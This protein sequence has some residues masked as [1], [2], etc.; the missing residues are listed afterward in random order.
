[1]NTQTATTRTFIA[2][3]VT[4]AVLDCFGGVW[5][6]FKHLADLPLREAGAIATVTT[7]VMWA[8]QPIFGVFADRGHMK[9]HILWGT[10]LTFPMMFLGTIMLALGSIG[11]SYG[12]IIMA[13]I[14]ALARLGQAMFH[15]AA[16]T[17]SGNLGGK[18]RST[19]LAIFVAA[20]AIG[21]GFSQPLFSIIYERA[22][23]H[24][25]YAL[26]PAIVLFAGCVYW[27]RPNQTKS[28]T[29][30][31]LATVFDLSPMMTPGLPRLFF[32][33]TLMSGMNQGLFFLL[34]EFLEERAY[35][36]WIVNGGGMALMTAGSTFAMIPVGLLADRFGVRRVFVTSLVLSFVSY[37][38]VVQ[39]PGMSVPAFVLI[40][41]A[42]GGLMSATNPLG[43]AIGQQISPRNMSMVS[44][45]LMGLAW[46]VGSVS[47]LIV[48]Y[49]ATIPGGSYS[50]ALLWLSVANIAAIALAVSLP[51]EEPIT[52]PAGA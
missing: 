45:M 18:R 25:E 5:P 32:V 43:L 24:T 39:L 38:V 22:N 42:A 31:S 16:A 46:S 27:C 44:G 40:S 29:K 13:A 12:L 7:V 14:V 3:L 17:L 15:P 1:M 51:K 10:I 11:M 19:Y 33:L 41:L 23:Y 9:S 52:A 47:Q 26:I 48:S 20:G 30:A 28:T 6:I 8:L 21:Y 36:T 50:N 4:H 49:L 34:P 2:V 35:P 37:V